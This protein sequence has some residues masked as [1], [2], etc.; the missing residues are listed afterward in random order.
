MYGFIFCRRIFHLLGLML[1][2]YGVFCVIESRASPAIALT[3]IVTIGLAAGI[4]FF[5]PD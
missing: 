1:G 3:A 2:G 5:T 4:A